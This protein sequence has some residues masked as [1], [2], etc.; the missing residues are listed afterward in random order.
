MEWQITRREGDMTN[1]R[2]LQLAIVLAAINTGYTGP[3]LAQACNHD[4]PV[5]TCNDGRRGILSGNA[6]IWPDGT[7][8]SASPHPSVI[9]GNKSSVH[10]G[11][12]V[13]VGQGTGSVPLDDPNAPNKTRCAILDGVSYCY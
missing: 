12:G 11:Q 7:R 2:M 3:A 1:G 5:V 13:F 4:G 9:I 6:I 10:V 8:S